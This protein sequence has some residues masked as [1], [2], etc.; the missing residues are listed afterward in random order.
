MR[1]YTKPKLII[2][3]IGRAVP[4]IANID[5]LGPVR[6]HQTYANRHRFVI[7]YFQRRQSGAISMFTDTPS[8]RGMG[9]SR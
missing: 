1:G 8:D 2:G 7:I 5:S 4:V 9:R 3:V 6:L